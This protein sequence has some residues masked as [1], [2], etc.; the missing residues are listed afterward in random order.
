MH[1]LAVNIDDFLIPY[2]CYNALIMH[3]LAVNIE[4]FLFPYGSY[5]VYLRVFSQHDREKKYNHNLMLNM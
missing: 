3:L 2:G 5:T 4:D 1:L